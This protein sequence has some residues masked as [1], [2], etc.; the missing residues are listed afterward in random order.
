MR[1]G[2]EDDY[3]DCLSGQALVLIGQWYPKTT[4]NK[5]QLNTC[6]PKQFQKSLDRGLVP[7]LPVVCSLAAKVFVKVIKD[8]FMML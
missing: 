3:W 6:L 1:A 5:S 7:I 4:I 2:Q 8:R